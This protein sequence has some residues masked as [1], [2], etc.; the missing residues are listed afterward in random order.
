VLPYLLPAAL[1][2]RHIAAEIPAEDDRAVLDEIIVGDLVNGIFTDKARQ[3]CGRIV[4]QLAMRGCDA[5]PA[6]APPS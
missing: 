3:E 1:A 5:V 6:A 4:E 2:T